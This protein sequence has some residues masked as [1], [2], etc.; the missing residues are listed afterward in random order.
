MNTRQAK[1]ELE[2]AEQTISWMREILAECRRGNIHATSALLKMQVTIDE[3]D[4]EGG[5]TE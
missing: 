5:T 2:R 3:Y 4:N 1:A